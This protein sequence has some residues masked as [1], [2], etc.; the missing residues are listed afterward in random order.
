MM[1]KC[2]CLIK[3]QKKNQS[4]MYEMFRSIVENH[5]EVGRVQLF[6]D[7]ILYTVYSLVKYADTYECTPSREG[8]GK[9]ARLKQRK[10]SMGNSNSLASCP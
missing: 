7:V 3:K 9:V 2:G 8:S 1:L 6:W 5:K 10:P 4:G